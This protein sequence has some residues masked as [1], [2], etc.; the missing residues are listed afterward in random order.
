MSCSKLGSNSYAYKQ[1][2]TEGIPSRRSEVIE[3]PGISPTL[4]FGLLHSFVLCHISLPTHKGEVPCRLGVANPATSA[5][6]L[7]DIVF[8]IVL[9]YI[10]AL[11]HLHAIEAEALKI[12]EDFGVGLLHSRRTQLL[13]ASPASTFRNLDLPIF[14][15]RTV[16][17]ILNRLLELIMKRPDARLAKTHVVS[18]ERLFLAVTVLLEKVANGIEETSKQFAPQTT[19]GTIE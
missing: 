16:K 3:R 7:L 5:P 11:C 13:S 4:I 10:L 2:S 19:S 15:T 1:A 12:G 8:P 17:D 14:E 9:I 6:L 18:K